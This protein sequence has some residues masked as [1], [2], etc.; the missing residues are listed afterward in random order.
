MRF[1][2]P[3]AFLLLL[4]I[5]L[6]LLLYYR[7]RGRR[8]AL[9]FSS[10]AV[11]KRAP[12]SWRQRLIGLPLVIRTFILILLVLALARPQEGKERVRDI[13]KGIAIEMVVDRSGSMGAEM[14]FD[15]ERLN[16]LEVVKRVF[17]EFVTG[18]GGDLPG[19]PNDMIGMIS[20]ARYADTSC[21][22][23]LAHGAL[24]EFTKNLHLVKRRQEDGTAIGDA[25]A[26]AAAR[27][28]TAEETILRQTDQETRD[29]E[30][31]SKIIILLTDGRNN[32]GKRSPAEAAALAKKWGIKIYTIG[33]GGDEGVIRQ[34]SLFGSFLVRMGEGVDK[35]TL[36]SLANTTGGIFRLAE[37]GDSLR[38][39]YQEIDELEKSEI[40]SVLFLDYQEL[41]P[42]LVYIGLGLLAMEMILT[43]TVFRKIP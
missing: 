2:A 38:A 42:T 18:R 11:A 26:L 9:R 22:L 35:K 10:V 7:T 25:I 34:H 1:E 37:D 32:A 36:E 4:L 27:L 19:R 17:D 16:R 21:P 12:R 29:F 33:V 31:K 5:P 39:I 13:S 3:W 24:S 20:F 6:L 14:E 23:T 41:F 43:A 8:S 30:I 40:E 15:G 28:K